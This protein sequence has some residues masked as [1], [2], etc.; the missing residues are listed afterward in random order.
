M[1]ILID[2]QAAQSGSRFRGIGR[3]STWLARAMIQL[4]A[5]HEFYLL[6]NGML[7]QAIPEI[8]ARFDDVLPRTN[9]RVWHAVSPTDWTT[10]QNSHRRKAAELIR[11]AF[12]AYLAPDV[13]H[14]TCPMDG[15]DDNAIFSLGAFGL[16]PL[17]AVT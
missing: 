11:E 16:K 4:G 17:T 12:I 1:R 9:I 5:E 7:P 6:L 3:Y 13:V 2:L 10:D 14:V 15:Y 8:I